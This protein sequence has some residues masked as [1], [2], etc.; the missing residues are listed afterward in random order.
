MPGPSPSPIT[1]YP[2]TPRFSLPQGSTE[3]ISSITLCLLDRR[4]PPLHCEG[5]AHAEQWRRYKKE[6]I[7]SANRK[8][9]RD[10][11]EQHYFNGHG[12]DEGRCVA[13]FWGGHGQDEDRRL[14]VTVTC[15]RN[16]PPKS[17][18]ANSV[19]VRGYYYNPVS[20]T[21]LGMLVGHGCGPGG[22]DQTEYISSSCYYVVYVLAMSM[23]NSRNIEE[24][25][26]NQG[27][28]QRRLAP[29]GGDQGELTE[30]SCV[31]FFGGTILQNS[32][33][34]RLPA[35]FLDIV[36]SNVQLSYSIILSMLGE[37][38]DQM[39]VAFA[40][41][42]RI[43]WYTVTMLGISALGL[44]SCLLIEEVNMRN[45]LDQTRGTGAYS[46]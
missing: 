16:M 7:R 43:I 23:E 9:N 29:K 26:K 20:I 27:L 12:H 5:H 35:E 13:N 4:R 42:V 31:K 41:G 44:L 28:E 11:F 32:L 30:V 37:L 45:A 25:D 36:I 38:R 33:K 6:A 39:R 3:H 15:M 34:A 40:K 17:Q 18:L 19:M 14:R 21:V 10:N 2:T 24:W 8:S 46:G 1:R 22:L